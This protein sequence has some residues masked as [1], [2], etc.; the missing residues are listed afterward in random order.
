MSA[1]AMGTGTWSPRVPAKENNTKGRG[2][3]RRHLNARRATARSFPC[4]LKDFERIRDRW[5]V[6][7][8]ALW[9]AGNA[10]NAKCLLP[11][12]FLTR[13]GTTPSLLTRTE[14]YSTL[15]EPVDYLKCV[16]SAFYRGGNTK[17]LFRWIQRGVPVGSLV[18]PVPVPVASCPSLVST[19]K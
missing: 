10:G 2:I 14:Q 19:A 16:F 7:K 13:S 4:T 6:Q 3:R 5:I 17:N 8:R 11:P 9:S 12:V 18:V 1:L 15:E